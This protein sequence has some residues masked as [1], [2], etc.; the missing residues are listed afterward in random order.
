MSAQEFN[1]LVAQVAET[2]DG[3]TVD[4]ALGD[5]HP[6]VSGGDAYILYLLPDGAIEFTGR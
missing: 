1:A 5:H 3:R 6:T 4:E 2:L